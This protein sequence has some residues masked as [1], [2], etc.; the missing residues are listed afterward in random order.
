MG[1]LSDVGFTCVVLVT[2]YLPYGSYCQYIGFTWAS[3]GVLALW[4]LLS[5]HRVYLG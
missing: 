3:E 4:E 1:V 2:G 5:I